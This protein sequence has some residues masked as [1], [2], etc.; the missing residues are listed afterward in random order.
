MLLIDEGREER[1]GR[2]IGLASFEIFKSREA[3]FFLAHK[4]QCT[5]FFLLLSYLFTQLWLQ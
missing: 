3:T 5:R 1:Q 4:L 2:Q